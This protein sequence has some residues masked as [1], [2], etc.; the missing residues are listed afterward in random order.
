M[1]AAAHHVGTSVP[2]V[3]PFNMRV[4][5]DGDGVLIR[6]SGDFDLVSSGAFYAQMRDL[7]WRFSELV[8]DLREVSFMDSAAL[9]SLVDVWQRSRRDGFELAIVR[10]DAQVQKLFDL[11]F[12][13]GVMPLVG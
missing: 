7:R 6:L 8:I 9:Q 1:E 3:L 11:T 2:S 13:S 12:L 4:V 10:G 5:R